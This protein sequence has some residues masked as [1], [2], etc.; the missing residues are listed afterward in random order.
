MHLPLPYLKQLRRILQKRQLPKPTRIRHALRPVFVALE[1]RFV[2]N[3]TAELNEIGQLIIRGDG[4]ADLVQLDVNNADQLQLRDGNGAIIPIIG[5]PGSNT[6]PL[7]RSAITSGQ[8]IIDLGGGD[9]VLDLEIPSGLNVSV[10]DS[11]GI[12]TTTLS[13]QSSVAIVTN[14]TIDVASEQI[15]IESSTGAIDLRGTNARFFGDAIIGAGAISTTVQLDDAFLE[16]DGSLNLAGDVNL[17]GIGAKIDLSAATLSALTQGNDL[18]ISLANTPGNDVLLGDTNDSAGSFVNNVIVDSASSLDVKAVP[19]EIGGRFD[20]TGIQQTVRV[21]ADVVAGSVLVNA[22]GNV[23]TIGSITALI[24]DIEIT[25]NSTID[26]KCPLDTSSHSNGNIVIDGGRVQWLN[27]E[28]LTSG[29][30]VTV[31]G[32]TFV[33]GELQ[34]DTSFGSRIA[35]G[36]DIVIN[37]TIDSVRSNLATLSFDARGANGNGIIT[38]AGAVGGLSP[39]DGI[40]LRASLVQIDSVTLRRGDIV[41][42]ASGTKVT[43][44]SI[45]TIDDIEIIGALTLPVGNLQIMGN[46]VAIR[47]VASGQSGSQSLGVSATSSVVFA[48]SIVDFANLTVTSQG[49]VTLNGLVSLAGNLVINSPVP[50]TITSSSIQTG[51][52]QNYVGGVHLLSSGLINASQVDFGVT[53]LVAAGVNFTVNA[54]VAGG[55]LDKNGDGRLI[56]TSTNLYT[57]DTLIRQGILQIDGETAAAAGPFRITSGRLEGSG[58]IRSDII[59]TAPTGNAPSPAIAP[60]PGIDRLTVG[61]LNLVTS[62]TVEFQ[63]RGTVPGSEYDQLVVGSQGLAGTIQLGSSQLTLIFDAPAQP[64]TEYV[65]VRNDGTSTV[66]G[67]FSTM[68]STTGTTLTSPRVLLEG[69]LVS[70][71]FGGSGRPAYITYAGGDGN[72]VAIVTA[73]DVT[74]RADNVTL[75]QRNGTN[76]EIRTGSDLPSAQT[77]PPIIRPIA[78]INNDQVNIIGSQADQ[79]L[80]V[81]LN[82][83]V[84]PAPGAIQYTGNIVFSGGGSADNDIVTILDLNAATDDSPASVRYSLDGANSGAIEVVN[85]GLGAQFDIQFT[86]IESIQ[87]LVIAPRVDF[88]YSSLD[89]QITLAA[90]IASPE[91]TE[92]TSITSGGRLSISIENPTSQL[93][94]NAGGG[95]DSITVAGFGS[96]SNGFTAA[97]DIDGE[98]GADTVVVQADLTLGRAG[99]TGNATVSAESI[100]INGDINTTGG[101]IDGRV[102]LIGGASISISQAAN[103]NAGDASIVVDANG[104][105]FNSVRG[106]LVSGSNSD[107]VVIENASRVQ[108]GNVNAELGRFRIETNALAGNITQA[109][110]TRIIVD[111]LSID[112]L[113]IV[114]LSNRGNEVANVERIVAGD[115]VSLSDSAGDL[116]VALI[117]SQGNDVTLTTTGNL[118][119]GA[120]AI[121][122][123]GATVNASASLAILDSRS[124]GDAAVANV[125]TGT[126]NALAG[127]GGI[128]TST[129]PL[130]IAVSESVNADTAAAGSDIL[131][132]SPLVSLPIGLIDAGTGKVTMTSVAIQDASGDNA[133]DIVASELRM[134]AQNGIGS[135]RKLELQNVTDI[136]ATTNSGGIRLDNAS[137]TNPTI[138]LLKA[139]SGSTDIR[140]S[141]SPELIIQRIESGN[142][143]VSVT[144]QDGSIVVRSDGVNSDSIVAGAGGAITLTAVGNNSDITLLDSIR[145]ATGNVVLSADRNMIAMPE[146]DIQT[147]GGS[148]FVTADARM[149]SF[150]GTIQMSDS[151]V[152]DAI[153]G[154]VRLVA[155]GDVTLGSIR[156]QNSADDAIV[157]ESTSGAVKDGGDADIDIVSNS[158]GAIITGLNGIGATNAIETSVAVLVADNR[159][160]GDLQVMESDAIDL[161]SVRTADGLINVFAGG[162]ITATEVISLNPNS[163]DNSTV[164]SDPHRDI[165]L[166]ANGLAS[167][168]LVGQIYA[169]NVTDVLLVAGDDVVN[170]TPA[171]SNLI[172]ADDLTVD[173]ANGTN[174][175]TDAVKLTTNVN[176]LVL[177]VTGINVGD[178]SINEVDAIELRSVSTSDG[179][180]TVVGGGT[181]TAT[182]VISLNPNSIDNSTV[183]SAPHRDISLRANGLASDILVGQI[184]AL[185]VTDVLLV[186]GDDVVNTTP[187]DSNLI[188]ADDLKVD[189]ANGTSD[190]TDA[191]K[192]TTNVNDLVLSVTG[193]NVGDVSINEVDAVELRSVTTA[194]GSIAVVANGTITAIEVTASSPSNNLPSPSRDIYLETKGSQSD[195]IVGTLGGDS[196]F[197]LT[198]N[199]KISVVAGRNI[200]VCDSDAGN[201]GPRL[202]QDVEI[203]ALGSHGQVLL[204]A[205]QKIE[206]GGATQLE[207][208]NATKKS[209]VID[210]KSVVLGSQIQLLTGDGTG[211]VRWFSPRPAT[212]VPDA[213]FFD[214]ATVRRFPDNRLSGDG[215][216][217]GIGIFS[218]LIGQPGEAGFT[219]NIDW[220]ANTNRFQQFGLMPDDKVDLGDKVI[221]SERAIFGDQTFVTTHNYTEKDILDSTLNGRPSATDPLQVRFAVTHH[222][223]IFV[224]GDSIQQA[225][226]PAEQVPGRVISSTD[227]PTT[228]NLLDDTALL[229][230]GTATFF[231]PNLTIP[232]AFF[233][234]RQIIPEVVKPEI[235]VR[236]EPSQ[237]FTTSTVESKAASASATVNRDEHFQ[238]RILSLEP[239]GEDLAPPQ[240]LPDDILAGD[241]LKRLF[242]ELPDGKYEIQYVLGDGNERML[243]RVDI[244]NQ[245]PVVPGD[246][247]DGGKLELQ[248]IDLESILRELQEATIEKEMGKEPVDARIQAN[249]TAPVAGLATSVNLVPVPGFPVPG[250]PVPDVPVSDEA[251]EHD[252]H[253]AYALTAV[254]V[255]ANVRKRSLRNVGGNRPR[256][257]SI[258]GR[259]ANRQG[260]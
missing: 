219:I 28:L 123:V 155:D 132:A 202:R 115:D 113:G 173:A 81:D 133:V 166:R 69:S 70:Q 89:E 48:S 195:V 230:S 148:V 129:K 246:E 157:I 2:L 68:F 243:L 76:L 128:G 50:N 125:T 41:I 151:A 139:S 20:V 126:L 187:A 25:S 194:K 100:T 55:S 228:R 160:V 260:G 117:D 214:A 207:A 62:S 257:F 66:T 95:N 77:A 88:Q 229:E 94:V 131:L 122:A 114:A 249:E 258:S 32:P 16:I 233:P 35:F 140:H 135:V 64:A 29:G 221:F 193:T 175:G 184:T 104:G 34:I 65:L 80:F 215:N 58:R 42:D 71:D 19:F 146:G 67:A 254:I 86:Q 46:S 168:I 15:T 6:D 136:S 171:V 8:L 120:G 240:R 24:G 47:G 7:D 10:L 54:P 196:G 91:R 154:L 17:T 231:I 33:N 156:S 242:A 217:G 78:A 222:Q 204:K 192:L 247:L 134:T 26:L 162:T 74:I 121:V 31:S 256:R 39:L 111:R 119:L 90:D 209:I 172:T 102:N 118:A 223:S 73:G 79:A 208:F 53:T 83:F 45:T 103:I 36:G 96:G 101:I 241:N 85:A 116:A 106:S 145:T 22:V 27:A 12:D 220:G 9:D 213:A 1:P 234:V 165:S 226:A 59:T 21:D 11:T 205:E 218:V 197:L 259:F 236:V 44:A 167:D 30:R 164:A 182:K 142:G 49:Q 174:D 147:S 238:I 200:I 203:K 181:V 97:I 191:V 248:P 138:R 235:F 199:G 112:S 109:D 57:G 141:G 179:S 237:F 183:A 51:G 84:D 210:A 124:P 107:A 177:S 150:G 38:L 149:G 14:R 43:G 110:G 245:Q 37:G 144:H 185:N 190:G 186:A 251:S 127:V 225:S 93:A 163:V 170:T 252:Q 82:R 253:A 60:G 61:G 87:Q 250:F 169:M 176:D 227:N 13:F 4:L 56:L 63:I 108:L 98:A 224:T 137:N 212:G 158:G 72:D 75:I 244:R 198:E 99:V 3:A 40:T 153:T 188:M 216:S 239:G 143:N 232:V 92:F 18:R 178:V 52:S 201:D 189:A 23:S 130:V 161:R 159:G 211:I 152:I 5:H 206:L 105:T 180:I 255:A